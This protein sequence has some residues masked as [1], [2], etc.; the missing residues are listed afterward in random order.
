MMV[1][2]HR[3]VFELAGATAAGLRYLQLELVDVEQLF[4]GTGL[5]NHS[6]GGRDRACQCEISVDR[7]AGARA[8][9]FAAG[10]LRGR[11][12]LAGADLVIS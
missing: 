9:R 1:D 11:S 4:V 5:A 2:M 8:A 6:V 7:M 3:A 12:L 10:V